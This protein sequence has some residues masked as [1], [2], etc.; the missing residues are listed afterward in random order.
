MHPSSLTTS[1]KRIFI[2]GVNWGDKIEK[3]IRKSNEYHI[4]VAHISI[5]DRAAYPG[6]KFT[7]AEK[8][9]E[10]YGYDCMLVGDV[11]LPFM[12]ARPNQRGGQYIVNTG[13]MMRLAANEDMMKHRPHFAVIDID[14]PYGL[15]IIPIEVAKPSSEVLSR[16]HLVKGKRIKDVTNDFINT[17][18]ATGSKIKQSTKQKLE[19][20]LNQNKIESDIKTILMVIIEEEEGLDE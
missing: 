11:H 17:L 20:Y 10:K 8:A 14:E 16:K 1:A 12:Y 5:S 13:P 15:E 18:Q 7:D 9:L 3:C 19:K 6:H 4:L 2:H